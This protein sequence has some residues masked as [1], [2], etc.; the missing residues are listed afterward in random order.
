MIKIE[1]MIEKK[2]ERIE[3]KRKK[4]EEMIEERK[5]E[6]MKEDQ[7]LLIEEELQDHQEGKMKKKTK[8]KEMSYMWEVLVLE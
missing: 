1:E 7:N 8:I 3:R 4:I 5:E 2:E 6:I